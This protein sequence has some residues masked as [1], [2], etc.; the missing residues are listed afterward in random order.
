MTYNMFGG[1]L[2]LTQPINHALHCYRL[3]ELM[4][5]DKRSFVH[6]LTNVVQS[7]FAV[8]VLRSRSSREQIPFRIAQQWQQQYRLSVCLHR[9]T[10]IVPSSLLLSPTRTTCVRRNAVIKGPQACA[11]LPLKMSWHTP[12]I[13]ASRH[14]CTSLRPC[15]RYRSDVGH[16]RSMPLASYSNTPS[17][18]CVSS[19]DNTTTFKLASVIILPVL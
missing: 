18:N 19:G 6:Q 10:N 11:R 14:V 17:I 15:G 4:R 9:V 5:F 16:K 12:K 3:R 1:T 2:N 7:Y 8:V 13:G